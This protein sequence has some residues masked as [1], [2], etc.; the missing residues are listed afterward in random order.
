MANV[1][2]LK[3]KCPHDFQDK[4]YGKSNRLH[5]QMGKSKKDAKTLDAKWRCTVCEDKK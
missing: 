4:Q 3:C 2:V 5:N 1:K